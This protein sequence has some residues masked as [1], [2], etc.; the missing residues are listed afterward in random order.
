[1]YVT[2]ARGL[3]YG[4]HEARCTT[5]PRALHDDFVLLDNLPERRACRRPIHHIDPP[6]QIG[7]GEIVGQARAKP[8]RQWLI[9]D[10]H[11]IEIGIRLDLPLDPG[12]EGPNFVLGTCLRRISRTIGQRSGRISNG[13]IS[14]I[15]GFQT[16]QQ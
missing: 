10:D 6:G 2:P 8:Q 13:G 1:M 9:R 5:S 4:V 7:F 16:G 11:Q 3:R 14:A 15:P 12:A